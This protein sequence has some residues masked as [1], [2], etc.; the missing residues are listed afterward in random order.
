MSVDRD[1]DCNYMVMPVSLLLPC[2]RVA[3]MSTDHLEQQ[4][5]ISGSSGF[6]AWLCR[7]PM[8]SI[9]GIWFL[10]SLGG[11][12]V[13][14]FIPVSSAERSHVSYLLRVRSSFLKIGKMRKNKIKISSTLS[15]KRKKRKDLCSK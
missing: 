3:R 2:A 12:L 8:L 13:C 10:L 11:L 9:F 4:Y 7:K 14:C 15:G 1:G 5:G 6:L